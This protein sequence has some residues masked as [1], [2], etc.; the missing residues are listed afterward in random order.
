M[1]VYRLPYF[2]KWLG[3]LKDNT[4]KKHIDN[5]IKNIKLNNLGD[6]KSVGSGVLEFR[7][8]INT[9]IRLYFYK[10]GDKYIL[11]LAGG[12]KSTQKQ[13]IQKAKEL[14]ELWKKK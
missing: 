4:I 10:N 1:K 11:L 14:L 7:I 2:D 6:Y 8:H 3:K 13:D 9:G 12:N 5:K